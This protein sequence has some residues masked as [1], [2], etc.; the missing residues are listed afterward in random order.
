MMS[1]EYVKDVFIANRWML[2]CAGLW[3][4]STRSKLVQIPYKIYAI[5]VFL[6]VN[7][8]FTSTE[9]LSLF[10]THKNLYNFIKNVNFF[11]TH[12]MGAVKVIFWFFKGH[13]L[14][15]LMRTL[16]SPEFHYE[17]CEGFQPGLIWRKYRRI[18]FKY[19]LGFLALAHMTLS[20]SYIPPLLTVTLNPPPYQNGTLSPF[21][22]KLPY[23]SWMPF[24]Y[25]T[26]RSYLLALGYQAG[27]MFS[28]AYSIVGMD[29]LFMNIMNFIAAH[30]VI[31]Q[32][33]FASSKMRVLDP[34]QMNNEMKR[35]CRHLQTILRVSED[36]ER[37][38][39]YLTLGQL[40]ATLFILCTSLYLI[41]TTPASSKQFYAELVYMV[42]MGFQLYLYCWFGN[43][44]TLMASEIPVN[45][46]K[47][48]WYDCDQSFKKSMIFTMTRMQKP[49]YMTVGKFAPLTLQ[50]FVYIL[51]TSY[52]I[53]AVIKNTSI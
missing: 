14:R 31:L 10:Y 22:Q 50:T 21:Y 42:A 48:D 2:R 25:S 12:F 34:G 8:Y 38:H 9:F 26:P 19:S 27:P 3:T 20:S 5:V 32:G 52:S 6:F 28:Y 29:T 24:S 23:F 16:E 1:D 49:I 7:V 39:R 46:W 11:L 53:F 13:V 44:V 41:S 37:V 45:V 33:A 17:P 40:T 47:A 4:P 43:E 35:N 18:G 36:L 15:D 30:L 51:R